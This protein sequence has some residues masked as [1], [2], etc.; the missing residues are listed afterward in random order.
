MNPSLSLINA[1]NQR[2]R[3]SQGQETQI[4]KLFERAEIDKNH[5]LLRE[6]QYATKLYFLESG[7]V[8]NYYY[9][10][11]KEITSW[12]YHTN[13][14]FT[15]WHSFINS[16]QSFEYIET[17]NKSTIYSI[18]KE[19]YIKLLEADL[20]FEKFGRILMQE[21]LAFIDYYFKGVLFMTAKE[22]YELLLSYFPDIAQKVNLGHIASFLGITQE[23]LSRLRSRS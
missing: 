23:T 12:F 18:T 22:K 3:I 15:S 4:L 5:Q 2:T 14:F 21:Q 19:N 11:D 16:E 20:A 9:H 17:L 1:I 13:Q 6:D 10:N 8:R 7:I